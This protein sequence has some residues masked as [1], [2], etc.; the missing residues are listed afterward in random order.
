MTVQ[1]LIVGHYEG[2]L[3]QAQQQELQGLLST[4]PETKAMFD[5]HGKVQEAMEEESRKLVPPIALREATIVGALGVAA[6]SIGG[7]IATWLTA[8]V[9]AAIGSVVVVGTVIGV[10]ATS[11]DGESTDPGQNLPATEQ[12]QAAETQD[13]AT[14]PPVLETEDNATA[15]SVT[16]T[17]AQGEGVTQGSQPA[18]TRTA[19]SQ[20]GSP[21]PQQP[22]AEPS[23][24]SGFNLDESEDPAKLNQ[25]T[26]IRGGDDKK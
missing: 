23:D 21:S 18:D 2:T 14:V 8:K 22:A 26:T 13:N 19:R 15:T 9:A 11:G 12:V 25:P 1:E 3:N 4:S 16:A 5:Q 20:N 24:E 17:P 10:I 7:G 6:E